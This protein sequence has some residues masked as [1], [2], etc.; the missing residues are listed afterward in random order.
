MEGG[1][2]SSV[3]GY[4]DKRDLEAEPGGHPA[5]IGRTWTGHRETTRED[6]PGGQ[7][8]RK[9]GSQREDIDRTLGYNS[10]G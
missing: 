8:G 7:A 2:G 3:G 10:G 5:D 4:V 9:S 1:D 6:K